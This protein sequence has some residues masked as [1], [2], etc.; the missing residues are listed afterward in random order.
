MSI[1]S[2]YHA[3]HAATALVPGSAV[4]REKLPAPIP[5]S[6]FSFP[7]SWEPGPSQT[8]YQSPH[9]LETKVY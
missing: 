8:A 7:S 4:Q 9:L 5:R 6:I 1:S 3:T 2:V